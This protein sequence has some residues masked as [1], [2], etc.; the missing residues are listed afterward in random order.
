MA[1]RIG[2]GIKVYVSASRP[3]ALSDEARRLF[4]EYY[5]AVNALLE[6]TKEMSRHAGLDIDCAASNDMES[7]YYLQLK[8]LGDQTWE[9]SDQMAEMMGVEDEKNIEK[10]EPIP[11]SA[12]KNEDKILEDE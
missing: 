12:P 9:T 11:W 6:I 2:K 10:L 4:E 8:Y 1:N 5:D 3:N 7:C